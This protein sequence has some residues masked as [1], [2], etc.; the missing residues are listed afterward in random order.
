LGP[1]RPAPLIAEWIDLRI[2][3]VQQWNLTLER[4]IGFNSGVR[5]SYI[6]TKAT[7]LIY[8]RNINQPPASTLPFSQDRRPYPLY[9]NITLRDNG[10]NQIY[11]GLSA[12][13]ERRWERGLAFQVAWT[14][15]KN[16][17]DVDEATGR[18][19]GGPTLEDAFNRS[20]ERGDVQFSPRQ[21]FLSN[22]LWELP[23]GA[24]RRFLNQTGVVT[25]FVDGS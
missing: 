10:G 17:A 6:G 9:R 21:R 3:G 22:I 4:E 23:F 2:H 25:G 5:L 19:E 1:G 15:A 8:G 24:G 7:D 11:H 16:L 20:R 18:T 12:E 13:V 14:W